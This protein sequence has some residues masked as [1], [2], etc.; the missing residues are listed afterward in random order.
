M[1][2][3]SLVLIAAVTL[4]VGF[5]PVPPPKEKKPKPGELSLKGL[6]GTWTVVSYE[7]GRTRPKGK[8]V[9]NP[10]LIKTTITY[11]TVEIKDGKWVQKRTMPN[12]KT[13]R[14]VPYQ[15]VLD[16]TKSP[17]TFDLGTARAV[18]AN[19]KLKVKTTT[20]TR[21]GVCRLDG[22]QLTVTYSLAGRD[23]PA[24]PDGELT[25]GEYRWVLKRAKP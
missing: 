13:A 15:I 5:A 10:N 12:G 6:E 16:A 18:K 21:K 9:V 1:R 7:I 4:S 23:R 25:T 11:H 14:T 8:G 17:A 19:P 2:G 24:R 20:T 3:P 22:D